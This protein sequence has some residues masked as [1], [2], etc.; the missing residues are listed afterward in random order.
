[1]YGIC[2]KGQKQTC[3]STSTFG[4]TAG[5]LAALGE[6]AIFW[7]QYEITVLDLA[8]DRIGKIFF[9]GNLCNVEDGDCRNFRQGDLRQNGRAEQKAG[10]AI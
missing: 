6:V 5:G 8:I 3:G 2:H 1:M 10:K 9:E 7:A 4:G